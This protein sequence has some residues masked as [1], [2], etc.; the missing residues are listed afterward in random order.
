MNKTKA[1]GGCLGTFLISVFGVG[2][3][4]WIVLTMSPESYSWVSIIGGI[5][6]LIAL[7]NAVSTF[8][9]IIRLKS[10]SA[11]VDGNSARPGASH[12]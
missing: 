8:T 6:V 9:K 3:M 11:A 2:L 10:P 12:K 5:I 1:I 7:I 4:G